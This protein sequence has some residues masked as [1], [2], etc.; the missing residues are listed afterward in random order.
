MRS[1]DPQNSAVPEVFVLYL[2]RRVQEVILALSE[3]PNILTDLKM[4]LKVFYHMCIGKRWC[5]YPI[6]NRDLGELV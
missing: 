1:L 4:F 5:P 6:K 3:N 2:F